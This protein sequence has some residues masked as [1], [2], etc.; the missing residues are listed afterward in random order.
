MTA[1]LHVDLTA[2]TANLDRVRDTVA[3]AELMLVVKDDAYG[4]GLDPVVRAAAA[5]GVD[6]FGAFDTRT[7]AAVR[8]VVGSGPRVFA[9][10]AAS[11][12][13]LD[14]AICAGL[15]LGIGD[16]ELL[17]EL[18]D[19]ARDAGATVRV[20][21]KIDTGL[22]RNGVRPEAWPAFVRRAAQLQADGA[23]DVVGVWSHIAEASDAEDDDARTVYEWALDEAAAA[24]IHP[25]VRH[26]AA[27]AA[28]FARPEFRYDL[29][30]VGAFC[31][32]IRSAGGPSAGD[33]GLRPIA[34]LEAEVT[35]VHGDAAEL[36]IGALDGLPTSLAGTGAHVGTAEGRRRLEL[37]GETRSVVETWPGAAVGDTV[38]VFGPGLQGEGSSTDL[39]EL[40]GTI[41]EEI[42]V[43]VSPLVPRV[44]ES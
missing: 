9:W 19:A 22:H 41:G 1:R 39:A 14:T 23:I 20:H 17:E 21:L 37:V 25:P 40:I 18:G 10:I 29:V 2:L 43:R 31:Y 15:D 28:S 32:G 30:R 44:Y 12:D 7:G 11:R 4:H 6:W 42:A 27:S 33:L 24:G 5:A 35:A 16:A 8:A 13:D 3:P 34:R 38:T 36:G 26:L